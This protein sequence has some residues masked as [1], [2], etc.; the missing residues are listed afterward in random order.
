MRPAVLAVAAL[1]LHGFVSADDGLPYFATVTIERAN[2]SDAALGDEI[3]STLHVSDPQAAGRQFAAID[4]VSVLDF[5]DASIGVRFIER[6]TFRS[7]PD[8]TH[9]QDSFVID[10]SEPSVV[11]VNDA[12]IAALGKRPTIDEIEAF[13]YE[14]IEDK[15]YAQAF[16][17][18]SRVAA[19]GRGDCTEHA[20]LLAAMAR[21]NGYAAR[22]VLGNLIIEA[23]P[24]LYSF[25]HAWTE[26][27]DGGAWQIRDA[28]LPGRDAAVSGVRYLPLSLIEN[29]GPGYNL[30]MAYTIRT[31]P[32][33]ISGVR[34]PP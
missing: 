11:A 10:F 31:M 1:A 29:E 26:I 8:D 17:F 12:F 33:R 28:T 14:H 21:A 34:N 24:R 3:Q 20:V 18:A 7:V 5:D 27:H 22:V 9:L 23:G 19:T 15:T 6:P 4:G 32:S 25:G 30:G 2:D 13:V 16:D